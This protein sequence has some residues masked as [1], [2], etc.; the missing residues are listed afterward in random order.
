MVV[1]VEEMPF[2]MPSII[3][4]KRFQAGS[5]TFCISVHAVESTVL[6][7]PSAPSTIPFIASQR[8]PYASL[9]PSHALPQS[10][11]NMPVQNLMT[12]EISSSTPLMMPLI[13][14]QTA[15][16]VPE[17]R[18][19]CDSSPVAIRR[20][21]GSMV[22]RIASQCCCVHCTSVPKRLPIFVTTSWMRGQSSVV[23]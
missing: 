8:P 12:P 10:P 4:L 7:T 11:L 3:P 9:M 5:A 2:Q 6:M 1:A 16:T 23:K 19:H 17:M 22:V 21:M 15:C 18:F 14:V 20:T 13:A